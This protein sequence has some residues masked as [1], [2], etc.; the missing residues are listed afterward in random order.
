LKA[1]SFVGW[2]AAVRLLLDT[3]RVK[4]SSDRG[5]RLARLPMVGVAGVEPGIR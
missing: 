3:T 4:E 5:I 2:F 1:E